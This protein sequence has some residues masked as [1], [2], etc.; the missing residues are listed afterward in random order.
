LAEPGTV[1]TRLKP[2]SRRGTRRSAMEQNITRV[3]IQTTKTAE[4]QQ[5]EIWAKKIRPA[6][7]SRSY[8]ISYYDMH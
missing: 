6:P 1:R 4:A 2:S 7:E 5:R 8:F 3:A